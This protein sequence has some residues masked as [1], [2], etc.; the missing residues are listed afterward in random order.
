[1]P[2][3]L[4]HYR[5]QRP[6]AVRKQS[7]GAEVYKVLWTH[8][9]HELVED[10][11]AILI[12]EHVDL[13]KEIRAG[14][15]LSEERLADVLRDLGDD[16][17]RILANLLWAL[18]FDGPATEALFR[19]LVPLVAAP[20][21]ANDGNGSVKQ[22]PPKSHRDF[23]KI[24]R[25]L[26]EL[27]EKLSE[28]Q[29]EFERKDRAL[30][31]AKLEQRTAQDSYRAAAQ[32]IEELESRVRKLDESRDELE[33]AAVKATA[34]TDGLRKERAHQR[35]ERRAVEIERSDLIRELSIARREIER[36]GLKLASR[37]HGIDAVY[38][39][40]RTEQARLKRARLIAQGGIK[41]ELNDEWR[42]FRKLKKAFVAAHPEYVE[43]RPRRQ[44]AKEPL[45]L[46][47]LGGSG[48]IGRSCYL[49]EL[50]EHRILVDCGVKPNGS[51][52]A[53]PDLSRLGEVHALIL[54]HAHADHVGWVPALVKHFPELPIYCSEGTA[55]LLPIMLDDCRR[56]YLRK[57]T[58]ARDHAQYSRH[59]LTVDEE[60]EAGHVRAVRELVMTCEYGID[61]AIPPGDITFTFY[62]AGHVLGAASV[63]VKGGGRKI[64]FSG[65]FSSFPQLTVSEA[66]WPD[67]LGQIDL[68]VLEST[69]GGKTHEPIEETRERLVSFVHNTTGQN[70]GS[71]ILACFALGRA[72]EVL[73]LVT[74]AKREGQIPGAIP[75]HV[76]GMIKRVNPVYE[77]L[78]TFNVEQS[79]FNEVTGDDERQNVIH[80]AL[81]RPAIIITT[82][83]MMT[84]GPV[85]E[86]ARHLLPE[87]R[88][89]IILT[90]YQ[91]GEA[92]S[93]NL[94]KLEGAGGGSRRVQFRNEEN[95]PVEFEAA[96]PAELISLSGH[97][98][99]R[100]LLR[101]AG[102]L[103]PRAVALVHGEPNAQRELKAHLELLYGRRVTVDC[104]PD[105]L[106]VP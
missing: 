43:P 75:V 14:K 31:R 99:Q 105:Q 21:F 50:G 19:D 3:P 87:P 17:P 56:N 25:E 88:N 78:A 85:I 106:E 76:D 57:L 72:Q 15:L 53:H 69:Y 4:E 59:R 93:Q 29:K 8:S 2:R 101:Y 18:K 80:E 82:S 92:P 39:F 67:D 35:D 36:L 5:R 91:D 97:A 74:A 10:V 37:P 104:G 49:L 84:G 26:K 65:D 48:E 63:L 34:L 83:G 22:S 66:Q 94:L 70:N 60:Y 73:S 6:D 86:Y 79:E 51:E 24:V 30:E 1:M 28:A 16:S 44:R 41:Q 95:E 58:K 9:D 103:K 13:V 38:K 77:R 32:K 27:K 90:G 46:V 68:L 11:R 52:D 71:V 89:R 42:T 55:A 62:P 98:D 61:E 96:F 81:Q 100:G 102:K 33:A 47:A 20:A 40:V 64:F 23:K 7:A 45:R 12:A 54:T